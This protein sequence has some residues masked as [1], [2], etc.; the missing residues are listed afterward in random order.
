M[1]ADY[2]KTERNTTNFKAGVKSVLKFAASSLA[3]KIPEVGGIISSG[4]TFY[5]LCKDS[6]NALK[7]TTVVKDVS[8]SYNTRVSTDEIFV[9]VKY[10]GAKDLG[11]QVLCYVGNVVHYSTGINVLSGKT[12]NGE[13]IPDV[14]QKKCSGVIKSS[15]YDNHCAEASQNFWKY[16]H[17]QQMNE[18]YTISNIQEKKI[19]GDVQIS[20][21]YICANIN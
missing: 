16:N 7:K 5:D 4:I 9:F 21:P 13:Y 3:G 1:I 2:Q 8:C 6:I 14:I 12:E 20:V 19:A 10:K 17:K 15:Q 18:Y 11:N